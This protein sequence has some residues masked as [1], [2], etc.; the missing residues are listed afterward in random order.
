MFLRTAV[1]LEL[2]QAAINCNLAARE[3]RSIA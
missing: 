1:G 2:P 3:V